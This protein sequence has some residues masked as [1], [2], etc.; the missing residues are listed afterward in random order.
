MKERLNEE[1]YPMHTMD[2]YESNVT[3]ALWLLYLG[4]FQ[5]SSPAGN[6]NAL[7]LLLKTN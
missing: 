2:S 7:W 6:E 1:S 3:L 4:V 5:S